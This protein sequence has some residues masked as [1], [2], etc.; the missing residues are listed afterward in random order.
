M[1][2][3]RFPKTKKFISITI[4]LIAILT[5]AILTYIYKFDGV[6]IH[7]MENLRNIELKNSMYYKM[8]IPS[9]T[10]LG[11]YWIGILG[12]YG[13]FRLKQSKIDIKTW[14]VCV[15]D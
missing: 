4:I 9:H 8:Y 14:K 13:Y 10:S 15:A 5:V 11:N 6:D 2:I 1:I 7:I 3:W 12:G